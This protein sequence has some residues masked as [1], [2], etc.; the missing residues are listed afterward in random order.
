MQ[1]AAA[2]QAESTA[3]A[4]FP[5]APLSELEISE[6]I[7]KVA[8]SPT[9]PAEACPSVRHSQYPSSAHAS[10]K[11]VSI[12]AS[13]CLSVKQLDK[14]AH[15]TGTC[16]ERLQ[17]RSTSNAHVS[18]IT[19]CSRQTW[20]LI[21]LF[22]L[23]NRKLEYRQHL[24]EKEL[25]DMQEAFDNALALLRR[26]KLSLE[27]DVKAAHIKRL[28]YQQELQLLKVWIES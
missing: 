3:P 17:I 7:L 23:Q 20:F 24:L 15:R 13:A 12:V 21:L 2:S 14:H 6:Q 25:A 10:L 11:A 8:R 5:A 18:I 28:A 19:A 4:S 22:P 26:E 1:A 27:A 9:I 16:K